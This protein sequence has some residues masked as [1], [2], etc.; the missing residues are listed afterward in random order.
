MKLEEACVHVKISM[1]EGK[2]YRFNYSL[3]FGMRI[4]ISKRYIYICLWQHTYLI[5]FPGEHFREINVQPPPR[6]VTVITRLST[7]NELQCYYS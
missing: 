5:F 3:L 1:Q 2:K 4:L 6:E 7:D